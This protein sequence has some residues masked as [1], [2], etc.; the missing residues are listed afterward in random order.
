MVG[1]VINLCNK[2]E[3]PLLIRSRVMSYDVCHR[4]PLSFSVTSRYIVMLFYGRSERP[5]Y[6]I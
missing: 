5:L 4:Q 6:R 1:R 2:F 3:H